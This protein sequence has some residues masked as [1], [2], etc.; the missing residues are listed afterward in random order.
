MPESE[1]TF[2]SKKQQLLN[3]LQTFFFH[4]AFPILHII[5][6]LLMKLHFDL[7]IITFTFHSFGI[8]YL[9]RKCPMMPS[10]DYSALQQKELYENKNVS[11]CD[12][13]KVA[14]ELLGS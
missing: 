9:S 5:Q 6:S 8:F 3:N 12:V 10:L 1:I 14:L 4:D 7:F 13:Q 11:I 2:N